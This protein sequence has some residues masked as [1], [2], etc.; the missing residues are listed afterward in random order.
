MKNK[1]YYLFFL[2]FT[3]IV[4]VSCKIYHDVKNKEKIKELLKIQENNRILK[5]EN[6]VIISM[7]NKIR[8]CTDNYFLGF[9]KIN[10]DNKYFE[11]IDI[12]RSYKNETFSILQFND[13]FST[14]QELDEVTFATLQHVKSKIVFF[15]NAIDYPIILK[16]INNSLS[17]LKQVGLVLVKNKNN[18]LIYV[19]SVSIIEYTSCTK[20]DVTK[21]LA[22]L[23]AN[24]E[25]E[26]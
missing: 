10:K 22:D 3:F 12:I 21:I 23:S 14:I 26:L 11:T 9:Y 2:I 24:L 16:L 13:Y 20:K 15:P 25:T 1:S 6:S 19:F 18:D 4:I 5:I 7:H 8:L 17:Q